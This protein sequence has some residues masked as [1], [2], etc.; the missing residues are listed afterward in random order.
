MSELTGWSSE[1]PKALAPTVYSAV[2]QSAVIIHK[3]DITSQT[4]ESQKRS[5]H[6][7]YMVAFAKAAWAR[8]P[9]S[10]PKEK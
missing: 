10:L 2:M 6:F 3:I 9:K 5:A 1:A 8:G 4:V 7:V